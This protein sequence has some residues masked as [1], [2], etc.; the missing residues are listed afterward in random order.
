MALATESRDHTPARRRAG[1]YRA[2]VVRA[3]RTSLAGLPRTVVALGVVSLLTDLSSEMIYP[4][5][6]VFLTVTLG[7]GAVALGVIEGVAEATAS[8]LKLGSGWLTDRS[9][10][11]KPLVVAGYS[12]SGCA[13]P[14]I[15]LAGAWPAVTALRFVDRIGKGVRTSPRDALIADVTPPDRRGIAYGV[16]RAM[17]HAGAVLG[18]LVAAV[19]LASTEIG[20]RGVFLLAAVPAAAVIVVLWRAVADPN[21]PR[22]P[23]GAPGSS[24][25]QAWRRSDSNF[26]RLIGALALFGLG[27]SSDAFLLLWFADAGFSAT[28]IALLWAAHNLVKVGTTLTGG[29]WT[30]RLGPGRLVA[31]GWMVYVAVYLAFALVGDRP[32][33]LVALFLAYGIAFGFTEPA[34]RA[35]VSQACPPAVRGSAFGVYHA[36]VGL[37]ALPASV[38]FG[39]LYAVSGPGAAFGSG[40]A[41]AAMA[42]LVLGARSTGLTS[43]TRSPARRSG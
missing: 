10:R 8:L 34:E 32:W 27:N 36:V 35:W 19:L 43:K 21:R 12:V 22:P 15:G 7:A 5:L 28:G 13:R 17:D 20:L 31:A 41:L 2:G 6:P 11:R 33:V 40:A 1:E 37:T 14:L 39:A 9:G 24:P 29:R 26:R 18:P 25:L 38:V 30:D 42:L 16:H 4:L 3:L 23:A